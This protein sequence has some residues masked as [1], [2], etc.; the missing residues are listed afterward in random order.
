MPEKARCW[1]DN[2][3]GIATQTRTKKK[4]RGAAIRRK[5]SLLRW[6]IGGKKGN[7]RVH[8]G[9]GQLI[10][11]GELNP[12]LRLKGIT[13]QG[14]DEDLLRQEKRKRG[15]SFPDVA[16]RLGK[17]KTPLKGEKGRKYP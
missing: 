13:A 16:C 8:R 3:G 5:R 11:R 7:R 14:K 9:R 1:P 15:E 6:V 4:K 17:R 2:R 10:K 12:C